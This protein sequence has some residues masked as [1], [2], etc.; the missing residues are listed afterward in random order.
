MAWA[1]SAAE[2]R[3]GW[4]SSAGHG[5][6]ARTF[7]RIL[8]RKLKM[9]AAQHCVTCHC[10]Y[11]MPRDCS[12]AMHA[13]QFGGHSADSELV[14]LRLP[15]QDSR[16][17][18]AARAYVRTYVFRP[19]RSRTA[20]DLRSSSSSS[21]S[22]QVTAKVCAAARSPPGGASAT[23]PAAAASGERRHGVWPRESSGGAPRPARR[24]GQD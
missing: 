1:Q 2:V 22:R 8:R 17:P 24:S 13:T 3:A 11:C 7:G 16:L 21:S 12:S 9:S 18:H 5:T 19:W 10:T 15:V 23:P 14:R 6:A 20:C 4:E